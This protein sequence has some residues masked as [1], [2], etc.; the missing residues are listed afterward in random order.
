[1]RLIVVLAV[2]C[3][4]FAAPAGAQDAKAKGAQLFADQKC[5]LCHSIGDKGNKKG[6]LDDVGSKLSTA[7][8]RE[9]I[10]DSKGMTA[11]MKTTRKPEMKAYSLPKEDVDALVA[12]LS[13][14]KK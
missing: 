14:L 4:G 9:W 5:T 6:P 11:K 8:I 13:S 12:Y 3:V 10:T 2:L 7:E 1:M